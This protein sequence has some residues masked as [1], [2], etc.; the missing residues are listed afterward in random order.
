MGIRPRPAEPTTP[1]G[2][3]RGRITPPRSWGTIAVE[4]PWEFLPQHYVAP[5]A[6][7]TGVE[8]SR[9]QTNLAD[10]PRYLEK[11]AEME[12][13]LLQEMIRLDDPY[14]LWDQEQ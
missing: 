6:A 4:N 9:E 2:R 12:A 7:L 11:R 13:L 5:V 8:P 10:D 3:E 14:R 1:R